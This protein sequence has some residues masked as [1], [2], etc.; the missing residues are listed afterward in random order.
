MRAE[1]LTIGTEL[2]IGQVVNTNATFLARELAMLGIDLYFVTTVGDNPERILEAMRLAWERSDLVICTGGLGPTAD[3]LTHDMVARFFGDALVFDPEVFARVEK[4]FAEKGR[5]LTDSERKLAMFPASADRI[6][7]PAGTASG[8]VVARGEKR[9]MTF[10]GV[11]YE[12]TQMWESWARPYLAGV[13][14]ATT[15]SRLLKFA[16]ITEADA[17][18]RVSDLEEGVNPTVAP[19]AGSGEVHLRITAKAASEA[20]A[21]RMLEPVVNEILKRLGDYYFGSEDETL[22]GV[23]GRLLRERGETLAVAESMTAGL[24]ASR[25]TD[26]QGAS[27][28]FVGGSV[29]YQVAEKVRALG[30]PQEFVEQHGHVSP[31]VT[32][33]IAESIRALT[34]ATWGLGVTGYAGPSP[35]TPDAEVGHAY[36]ALTGPDGTEIASFRFGGHPREKVKL[37]ASQRALEMVFRRLKAPTPATR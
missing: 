5:Q 18:E 25:I 11:P 6:P 14:G 19:Y 8:V 24:V 33:A 2:L 20:E 36:V 30:L 10:P 7:N 34:G 15:R 23:V 27:D 28:Y 22:P 4:A 21:E 37:F 26:I 16:G 17:A 9:L 35:N 12:L 1:I 31:E 13:T 3:D 29:C 32:R